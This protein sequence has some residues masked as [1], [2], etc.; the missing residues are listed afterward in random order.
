M[1]RAA[2]LSL[3]VFFGAACARLNVEVDVL[4]LS[5]V[6]EAKEQIAYR[7]RLN[8]AL[9]EPQ[10]VV[11]Q[12]LERSQ[13]AV[14]RAFD[15]TAMVY[16]A[17]A[18]RP[19]ARDAGNLTAAA[20]SLSVTAKQEFRQK[21]FEPTLK[22]LSDNYAR[23]FNAVQKF[24]A[25]QITAIRDGQMPV[26]GYIRTF[27]DERTRILADYN[28]AVYAETVAREQQLVTA[29]LPGSAADKESAQRT[30]ATERIRAQTIATALVGPENSIANSPDAYFVVSAP[31]G[32]WGKRENRTL[33]DGRL[34]NVDAAIKLESLANFTIKGVTFDPSKVAQVASKVTTQSLLIA[35]QIAGVPVKLDDS[36]A[37]AQGLL[38]AST[39]LSNAE[40]TLSK[41]RALS[42]DYRAALVDIAQVIIREQAAIEGPAAAGQADSEAAIAAR[43]SAVSAINES[44]NAQKARLS[45]TATDPPQPGK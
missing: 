21:Y 26:P 31:E 24:S 35:A 9:T 39:T 12:T 17:A 10:E 40:I 2:I 4:D 29:N 27:L 34:G 33:I 15:A 14:F 30:I 20:Q 19:D 37:Q 38:Q 22:A 23:I 18:A 43:K 13:E 45:V 3:L 11:R 42:Q 8:L 36:S 6:A 5:Y 7:S 28:A 32:K 1:T 41:Q 16:R 25:D 44:F